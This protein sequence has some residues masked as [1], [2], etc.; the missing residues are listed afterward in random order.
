[1]SLVESLV[2]ARFAE[3]IRD[4]LARRAIRYL[5]GLGRE[6]V[7]S[8]DDAG[9]ENVWDEFCVQV[10][11]GESLFWESYVEVVQQFLVHEIE[12]LPE[13]QRDALWLQTPSGESWVVQAEEAYQGGRRRSQVPSCIPDAAA[14]IFDRVV[15]YAAEWSNARIRRFE[16]RGL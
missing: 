11:S 12:A 6:S 1:M 8:P 13:F 2:L 9:L 16:S 4:G 3:Q 15:E 10:Q 7:M 14:W 5:Q